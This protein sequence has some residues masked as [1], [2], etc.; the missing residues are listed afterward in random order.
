MPVT[1]RFATPRAAWPK[2]TEALGGVGGTPPWREVSTCYLAW[3][4]AGGPIRL[5]AGP[6]TSSTSTCRLPR[7]PVWRPGGDAGPFGDQLPRSTAAPIDAALVVDP[8]G[9][10]R[11]TDEDHP[12]RPG[13]SATGASMRGHAATIGFSKSFRLVMDHHHVTRVRATA[14]AAAR[15]ARNTGEF[16]RRVS[17]SSDA[18][19]VL[20][21]EEEGRLTFLGATAEL[22]PGGVLIS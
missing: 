19:E 11:T 5:A 1:R 22:D 7:H 9:V 4:L 16:A 18:P 8:E 17:R 21:G 6:V 14:T 13:L 20:D 10:S 15:D 12:A 2:R 3:F